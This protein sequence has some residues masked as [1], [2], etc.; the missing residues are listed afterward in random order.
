MH[1]SAAP[2]LLR[3]LCLFLILHQ[4]LPPLNVAAGIAGEELGVATHGSRF[5]RL[6][7]DHRRSYLPLRPSPRLLRNLFCFPDSP[8][9]T[10]QKYSDNVNFTSY[11]GMNFTNYSTDRIGGGDYYYSDETNVTI[12]VATAKTPPPTMKASIATAL[13]STDRITTFPVTAAKLPAATENSA[14]IRRS[15]DTDSGSEGFTGYGRNGNGASN[16]FR[17]Y[18]TDANVMTSR[19]KNYG[20]T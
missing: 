19:F 20:Q 2:P 14:I 15:N 17:N 12:S 8:L 3:H 16:E 6:H 9:R 4:S 10:M 18:D 7:Q 5:C 1:S 11:L 13:T